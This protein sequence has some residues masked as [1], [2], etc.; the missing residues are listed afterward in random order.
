MRRVRRWRGR[1]RPGETRFLQGSRRER[2]VF[3]RDVA[4][5]DCAPSLTLSRPDFIGTGEGTRASEVVLCTISPRALLGRA[6]SE[7][8]AATWPLWRCEPDAARRDG[9][10]GVGDR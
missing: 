10:R 1:R 4:L 2:F 5:A 9:E 6:D 3:G 8:R 7:H